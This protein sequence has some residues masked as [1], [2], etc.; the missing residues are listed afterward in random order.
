MPQMI[1]FKRPDGASCQGYFAPAAADD[2]NARPG[3]ILIQEW[4]GL[5]PHIRQLTERFAAA[6]YN[7]LAPDLYHGR[8]AKDADEAG[9]LMNGLDFAAATHQD[10]AGAFNYLSARS[11]K[12]G[13]LGFCLGGALTIASAV[14]L[15]GLAAASCFY[16]IP[17]LALA[18]PAKIAIPFQGHFADLDGWCTPASVDAMQAALPAS[19]NAEIN[20]Y[21]ANHAFFNDTRADVYDAACAKQAWD[22]TMAFFSRHLSV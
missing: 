17:P 1:E 20:R 10:L 7:V 18:D 6:G 8:I 16:G 12:V 19:I 22:R 9:K 21:P 11:T 2:A 4:W 5:N 14:H 3:L 15:Q 13:V